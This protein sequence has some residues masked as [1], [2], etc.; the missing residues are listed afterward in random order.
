MKKYVCTRKCFIPIGD[1]KARLY[2]PGEV[3]TF[4]RLPKDF[5]EFFRC[6]SGKDA[7][8]VPSLDKVSEEELLEGPYRVADLRE[9]ALSNYGVKLKGTSKEDVVESFVDARF[10]HLEDHEK[11]G[12]I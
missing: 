10:R 11:D 12:L 5:E 9:Y 6:I 7:V 1:R 2:T 3:Y 8:P 4:E